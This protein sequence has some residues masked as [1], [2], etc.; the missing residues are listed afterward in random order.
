MQDGLFA[1]A[2]NFSVSNIVSINGQNVSDYLESFAL[3]IN[4]DPDASYN[5]I[6]WNYGQA[7]GSGYAKMSVLNI[8]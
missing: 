7:P 1:G 6:L 4:S 5:T 2:N 8:H 3:N